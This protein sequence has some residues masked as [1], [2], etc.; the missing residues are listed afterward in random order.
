MVWICELINIFTYVKVYGWWYE[1]GKNENVY[2]LI[3]WYGII[4]IYIFVILEK[5]VYERLC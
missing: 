1:I 5:K 2:E 4:Y 3:W